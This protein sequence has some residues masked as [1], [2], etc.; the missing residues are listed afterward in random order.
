MAVAIPLVF[1]IGGQWVGGAVLGG[2]FG[3]VAGEAIGGLAGMYLGSLLFPQKAPD[4]G[5]PRLGSYQR[6]TTLTGSAIPI[7]YGTCRIAGN[8]VVL[9]TS[10]PY[11]IVHKTKGG[12]G[13]GGGSSTSTETRYK[14]SFLIGICEGPAVVNRVWCGKK[15]ISINDMVIFRGDGNSGLKNTIGKEFGHYKNLCCAWFEEY[16]LG[17]YD[18]VPSFTF[19]VSSGLSLTDFLICGGT[20]ADNYHAWRI[21]DYGE[22]HQNLIPS[23]ADQSY[24]SAVCANGKFYVSSDSYLYKFNKDGSLIT[25]WGTD[26]KIGGFGTAILDIALDASE[27][28]Y[29]VNTRPGIATSGDTVWKLDSDG[30]VLW[31]TLPL[32]W[33]RATYSVVIGSDDFPYVCGNKPTGTAKRGTKL[34]PITGNPI[35]YYNGYYATHIGVDNAGNVYT[36]GGKCVYKFL[37]DGTYLIT[38]NLDNWGNLS[39]IFVKGDTSEIYVTGQHQTTNKSVWKL[40]ADLTAVIATYGGYLSYNIS[41]DMDGTTLLIANSTASAG[42]N[43]TYNIIKLKVSNLAFISGIYLNDTAFKHVTR[44]KLTKEP[45]FDMN[46]ADILEDVVTN[47]RYA[48]GISSGIIQPAYLETVFNHCDTN[49]IEISIL[50]DDQ[51]PLLDWL[52]YI[53]SHYCGYAKLG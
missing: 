29:V 32:N 30:N 33:A 23:F 25:S 24:A 51:Q 21:D 43:G 3:V 28:V 4:R 49:E 27:N 9:G 44:Q 12:K 14:R 46:P 39:N 48:G 50:M 13:I 53:Q 19:E 10:H 15:E 40:S 45:P 1:G 36:S 8:I 2:V 34:S 20:V 41:L 6:Q 47:K 38:H 35:Y 17:N 7:V 18:R 11:A 5:L 16:E 22:V 26:G 31:S 37:N 52:D 42:D